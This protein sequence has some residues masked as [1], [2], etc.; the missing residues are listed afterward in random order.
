MILNENVDQ[1]RLTCVDRYQILSR[2]GLV[3]TGA[4]ILIATRLLSSSP[5]EGKTLLLAAVAIIIGVLGSRASITTVFDRQRKT[6]R[7]TREWFIGRSAVEY[8]LSPHMSMQFQNSLL[9]LSGGP[10]VLT[11]S[12]FPD[13]PISLPENY[14][15]TL[16]LRRRIE[17]IERFW[18]R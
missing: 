15:S 14:L 8:E 11:D 12:T 2:A 9:R 13:M 7:I 4:V 6:V 17:A 3:Y 5:I 18:H 1:Q 10:I 16:E